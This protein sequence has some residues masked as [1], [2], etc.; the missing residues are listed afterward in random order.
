MYMYMYMIVCIYGLTWWG[1]TKQIIQL[2]TMYMYV[3]TRSYL[4]IDVHVIPT[5]NNYKH[6]YWAHY[7]WQNAC[8]FA[9]IFENH[10]L[11]SAFLLNLW[12]K[13]WRITCTLKLYIYAVLALYMYML[14]AKAAVGPNCPMLP[15]AYLILASILVRLSLACTVVSVAWS[16][17]GVLLLN[18]HGWNA[19]PS[20]VTAQHF[21]A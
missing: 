2:N 1:A 16:W 5:K 7:D 6:I 4:Y 15:K 8:S 9:H 3:I 11:G 10:C 17:L 20:Q 18:S 21:V 14:V 12:K 19:S 13:L